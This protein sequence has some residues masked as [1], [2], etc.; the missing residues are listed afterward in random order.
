[1]K[2]NVLVIGPRGMLAQE[3]TELLN[4]HFRLVPYPNTTLAEGLIP[5]FQPGLIIPEGVTLCFEA[6]KIQCRLL[7]WAKVLFLRSL[8]FWWNLT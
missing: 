8:A 1:M 6:K 4:K 5:L 2:E 3:L 7:N